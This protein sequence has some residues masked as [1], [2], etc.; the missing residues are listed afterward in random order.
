MIRGQNGVK[1]M[2][3]HGKRIKQEQ[4]YVNFVGRVIQ[5]GKNFQRGII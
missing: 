4:K 1:L 2:S 5:I 3:I